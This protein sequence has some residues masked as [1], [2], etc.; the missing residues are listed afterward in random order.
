MTLRWEV[1]RLHFDGSNDYASTATLNTGNLFT[2]TAWVKIPAGKSGIQTIVANGPSGSSSNAFKLMV[3]TYG[4]TDRKIIFE[5][6]NGSSSAVTRS[7]AGVFSFDK[8]NHIAVS[9]NRST[10]AVRLYLNGEDVTSEK[11]LHTGFNTTASLRLGIM[12][13]NG[14]GM[15]GQIDDARHV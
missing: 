4:T 14:F 5:S 2:F 12:T 6:G 9:V 7:M 10:G 11:G 15:R 8:W 3:N 13:N 1:H